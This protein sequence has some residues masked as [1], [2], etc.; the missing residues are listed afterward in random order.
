MA[1]VI[2]KVD[3]VGKDNLIRFGH[4]DMFPVFSTTKL[5]N[6]YLLRR[7]VGAIFSPYIFD[8]TDND[9]STEYIPLGSAVGQ[10]A[11]SLK[12][13][14]SSTAKVYT[15]Q[16]FNGV[17][18]DVVTIEDVLAQTDSIAGNLRDWVQG[19]IFLPYFKYKVVLSASGS[20]KSMLVL[21]S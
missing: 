15:F 1:I 5:Q 11:I 2:P 8:A 18:D 20:L 19:P 6:I 7:K 21:A 16:S 12:F 10:Y 17:D 3:L 14:A 13:D 9:F 4:V